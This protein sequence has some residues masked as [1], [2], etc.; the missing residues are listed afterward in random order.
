[1]SRSTANCRTAMKWRSSRR[2]RADEMAS[3]P[4]TILTRE[5]ISAASLA[6]SLRR[7]D[8]GAIATFEGTV[9][10]DRRDGVAVVA[11]DYSAHEELALDQMKLLHE[12]AR[13]QFAIL[14]ARIAHRLGRL[15]L[16]E[17]SVAIAVAAGHRAAAFDACRW[18]IDTLKVDVPIWKKD[19]WAD[20]REAW[21]AL[22]RE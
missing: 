8:A 16:G 5:P 20:G 13:K 1:M 10:A 15:K 7:D 21:A 22:E 17:V 2:Y 18:L 6:D 19:I 3:D 9:R 12:R 11:L 4:R 14:D